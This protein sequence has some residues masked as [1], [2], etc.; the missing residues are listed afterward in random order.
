MIGHKK[1]VYILSC[2]QSEEGSTEKRSHLNSASLIAKSRFKV[3]LY[4]VLC[5]NVPLSSVRA[6]LPER[7]LTPKGDS[8]S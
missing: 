3:K 5:R 4:S 7:M 2:L 6:I 8:P 1:P